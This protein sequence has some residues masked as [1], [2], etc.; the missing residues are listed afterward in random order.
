M[1]VR[2]N[3][4]QRF[5]TSTALDVCPRLVGRAPCS[6]V[7]VPI[8]IGG[9][10][11]GVI[12]ATGPQLP[13]EHSIACL[14]Q[15]ALR[16]GPRL[17]SLRVI[18]ST[19][20]AASVDPLT[21]LLNRRSFSELAENLFKEG[22]S[23]ALVMADID[24]FKKLNDTYGHETGDRALKAFADAVRS[25]VR[26]GDMVARFG[27]EEFVLVLPELASMDAVGVLERI[28]RAIPGAVAR[29]RCPSFTVSFGVADS[30]GSERIEELIPAADQALYEAK[31]A[32]RDRIHVAMQA[33]A[34]VQ[35][36]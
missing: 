10:A 3:Q 31:A 36:G 6:A 20:Q 15:V 26:G 4:V 25:V 22:R 28:Q 27:G 18:K 32:G 34:A 5:A 29:A 13:D 1:A 35:A 30:E 2:R 21:G 19:Q 24:H 17:G 23:F 7:C 14:E 9:R 11:V 16:A 8:A 33:L 12:H